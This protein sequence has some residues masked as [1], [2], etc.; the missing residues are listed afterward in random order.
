MI[1]RRFIKTGA[2]KVWEKYPFSTMLEQVNRERGA[3][4][5]VEGCDRSGKTTQ[6]HLL[7]KNLSQ[8]FEVKSMKYPGK[9]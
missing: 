1:V 4:I 8:E 2:R 9:S 6:C 3:L 5:I 7:N